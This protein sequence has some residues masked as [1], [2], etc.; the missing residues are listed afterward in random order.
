VDRRQLAEVV[1]G[2]EGG[3][4]D[5]AAG[6][7]IV[8]RAGAAMDQEEHLAALG[9]ALEDALAGAED[10]PAATGLEALAFCLIEPREQFDG[11][12][13]SRRRRLWHVI[14]PVL[15]RNG[16][17]D[18]PDHWRCRPVLSAVRPASI[19]N[20]LPP[21]STQLRNLPT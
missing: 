4:G 13:S 17:F 18:R 8:E 3:E 16:P 1:A 11:G 12:K 21:R 14:P 2:A 20:D 10:P 19:L 6:E 5:L 9:A 15:Y 7:R